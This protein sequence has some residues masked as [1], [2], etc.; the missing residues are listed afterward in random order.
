MTPEVVYCYEDEDARDAARKMEEHQLRRL[1]VLSH[2]ERLVGILSL[3][4][5]AVHTADDRLAGEVAEA[6]SEPAGPAE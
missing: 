6:V 2:D 1:I 4:D 5:L 3:G